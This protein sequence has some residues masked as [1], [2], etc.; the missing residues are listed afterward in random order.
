M[1]IYILAGI[2]CI[3]LLLAA[4]AVLYWN[5]SPMPVVRLLRKGEDGGLSVPEGYEEACRGITVKKDISYPS[6][7]GRNHFDLYLPAQQEGKHPVILWVHGG[8]FVAGDKRGVENWGYMLA[9][10]GYAVAAMNYEWA[11]E[12]AY[13]AQLIQIRDCLKALQDYREPALQMDCVVLAGDSAGA[14]MAAQFAALHTNTGLSRALGISSPLEKDALK[15][16]LL[17]CGPYDLNRML[18]PASRKLGFFIS[19]IGWSYFGK[20]DWEN[21]PLAG[22]VNVTGYV[23]GSY[24]PAY[25][26]D[27]NHMSF[28]EH[29]RLLAQAL[30]ENGVYVKT[31]F[32]DKQQGDINHEYQMELAQEE[33]MLCFRD[34]GEFLEKVTK[35]GSIPGEGL[36]ED[37]VRENI[38][39]GG[40][41]GQQD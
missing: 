36:P 18:K 2:G 12:A 23:A 26:T 7:Y 17:Y 41:Y 4:G 39:Q 15:G 1:G 14:H 30:E 20:K 35:G 9:S 37:A 40:A 29:G 16:V 24:P 3:C 25:I 32:F 19:R 34:T 22:T 6:R 33:A 31:R 13:P 10:K 5:C 21:S 28:E 27:G 8:A 38:T 11:P